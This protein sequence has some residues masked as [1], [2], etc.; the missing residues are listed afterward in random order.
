M[1]KIKKNIKWIVLIIV[2]IIFFFLLQK[3]LSS[4]I[5]NFDKFFHKYMVLYLRS[6][7]LTEV[8]KIITWFASSIF[9]IIITIM[10]MMFFKNKKQNVR[11][12]FNLGFV[13][14]LN[15]SLKF[16]IQR[17]RPIGYSL[18]EEKGYSFPSGHSMASLAFYGYFIYL[19]WKSNRSKRKKVIYTTLLSLLIFSI[20]ISRIYLGVHYASDVLA[21]MCLSL[22]YLI[23]YTTILNKKDNEKGE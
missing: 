19:I 20:G 13:V 14:L 15:Q 2:C 7:S 18:I 16:I 17:E 23:V 4:E 3:V 5:M 21:G 11:F 22:V 1:N 9:L 8:M 10:T 6:D 12:L